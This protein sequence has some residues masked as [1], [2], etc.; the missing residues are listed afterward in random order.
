MAKQK[1]GDRTITVKEIL[2]NLLGPQKATKVL[3]KIQAEFDNPKGTKGVNFKDFAI[4][5]INEETDNKVVPGR[6][7]IIV[8]IT[9]EGVFSGGLG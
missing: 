7:A 4:H 8:S 3:T 5:A 1:I 9:A 2:E 6:D